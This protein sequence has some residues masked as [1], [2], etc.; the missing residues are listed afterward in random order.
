MEEEYISLSH[1]MREL[2]GIIEVIKEIQTFVIYGK[3]QNPKYC[4]HSKAFVL[5]DIPP[6]KVYED[7]EACMKFS[8]MSKMSPRRSTL[9]Y[10]ITSFGPS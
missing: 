6:S 9:P 3:T 8:T 10:N 2:I 1:S 5:D 7:N 4:T